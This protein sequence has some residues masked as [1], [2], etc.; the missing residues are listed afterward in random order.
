MRDEVF[1]S[2]K[3]ATEPFCNVWVSANAGSG[4]THVLTQR[5]IR[6]LLGGTQPS[7]ILCLTYTNIAAAVMKE[8]IFAQ[9]AQWIKIDDKALTQQLLQL[10]GKPPQAEQL[11]AARR[12][13]A[14]AL[15]T[16]GGL[17]I[18]TIHAFCEALLHQFPLEAN[19]AGHFEMM[20][21]ATAEEVRK[22][23]RR[24][25]LKAIYEDRNTPLARA[26]HY[27]LQEASLFRFEQFLD[28]LTGRDAKK[29]EEFL[30]KTSPLDREALLKL[31]LGFTINE[32]KESY[33]NSFKKQWHIDPPLLESMQKHKRSSVLNL[34]AAFQEL[35][36]AVAKK[37]T[38]SFYNSLE[39]AFLTNKKERRRFQSVS[40][41]LE[42]EYPQAALYLNALQ[43]KA[44]SFRSS[45]RQ[46]EKLI[47]F[48]LACYSLAG[49]FLRRYNRLKQFYNVLDFDDA[50]YYAVQL[51]K[52]SG[53]A[54]WVH[55]KLDQGIEHILVDEAQDTYSQQWQ[56]IDSLAEEF[57]TGESACETRRTL[58]AV[59]DEKQ[60]IY[61]FQ[62]A[63]PEIFAK[64]EKR[65]AKKSF[66]AQL[67]FESVKLNFSFRSAPE[68]LS[69]VDKV[70]SKQENY[71]ALSASAQPTKHIAIRKD[72]KGK[73]ALWQPIK[74]EAIIEED[75]WTSVSA[76]RL[77]PAIQ[78]A[79][80][81][82]CEIEDYLKN[83]VL[84]TKE[85]RPAHAGDF[86]ILVR[87]RE[88]TFIPAL[89]KELKARHIEVAGRDK[90]ALLE[91]LA[92]QDLLSL[93]EFC[94][95]NADDFSLAVLFKSPF[96]NLSEEDLF[97]IAA[98]RSGSLWQSLCRRAKEAPKY[99][100]MVERLTLY[101][102]QVRVLPAYEFYAKILIEDGGRQHLLARFGAQVEE[103]LD[104]FMEEALAVQ[105]IGVPGVEGF[106][107]TLKELQ[108]KIDKK[109]NQGRE[110][111]R[112]MTIHGAKGL[113][114]PVVFFVD[115]G[116]WSGN[117]QEEKF[118]FLESSHQ[119][120]KYSVPLWHPDQE[121]LGGKLREAQQQQNER[122]EKENLRLLYVGMT[123][124]E[125]HLI[126]C[127][128]QNGKNARTK[129]Y[130]LAYEALQEK[131]RLEEESARDLEISL[132]YMEEQQNIEPENLPLQPKKTEYSEP[133]ALPSYFF[134]KL[135]PEKSFPLP[136]SPSKTSLVIEKKP[137][138]GSNFIAKGTVFCRPPEKAGLALERGYLL[139]SVL[140]HLPDLPEE[141]RDKT[142]EDFIWRSPFSWDK[143]EK[144]EMIRSVKEVFSTPELMPL[145]DKRGRSEVAIS[146]N[147]G[148]GKKEWHVAGRIDRLRLLPDRIL[149]CD[150]KTG[151]APKSE[152]EIPLTH[153]RQ[154]ALYY[155][156]LR[157]LYAAP[158]VTALLVYTYVPRI[159]V[160]PQTRLDK[161]LTVF[162][163]E[164][165]K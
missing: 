143:K 119:Q 29:I 140:Q 114:A 115:C 130:D 73:V 42:G 72:L 108:P 110:E 41:A 4:K 49:D 149:F 116:R 131:L 124:A 59:G 134:K 60:S 56:I 69:A 136:L 102:K 84:L 151:V 22:Q 79:K 109:I 52:R 162:T 91:H 24:A 75:D 120:K 125:E 7:R 92:I 127:G 13:F 76:E 155:A 48:N 28:R 67:D 74:F 112:I 144:E 164:L 104:A 23:A 45:V 90:F 14:Q 159:F 121:K 106:L 50:I 66:A 46:L 145:F 105:K 30:R 40:A 123:R 61:S 154:M 141:Q 148:L 54:Q 35:T 107:E 165:H 137:Y 126:M 78:L 10:E 31:G 12:L 8:R 99:Q 153:M 146:G 88:G 87:K 103:A 101:S 51:L 55:Y 3:L 95:Q 138:E 158:C 152:E 118:F 70:F 1:K 34:F 135:P 128:Y 33:I 117:A 94:L 97:D 15:E 160:L 44:L 36:E 25:Q 93:G 122:R 98:E 150:Y 64:M 96:F 132:Y 43:E 20:D 71:A 57:F 37:E 161:V 85:R 21:N 89:E 38:A 9:L 16:P 53:M 47:P 77:E 113:E 58:F 68:I 111:V 142:L 100:K 65:I 62:G 17:K 147:I 39:K 80:H 83:R 163:Q 86:L 157:K 2:Q 19:I 32:T 5:V 156:L 63:R 11:A 26:F 139:H 27:F 18:Q 133:A 81:I 6:L 82:A 129:C